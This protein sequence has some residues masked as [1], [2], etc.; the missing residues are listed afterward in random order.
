MNEAEE[1]FGEFVIAGANAA[2][3]FDATDGVFDRLSA[4]VEAAVEM[5]R[6]PTNAFRQNAATILLGVHTKISDSGGVRVLKYL[7]EFHLN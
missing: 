2:L 7:V 1:N 6:V 3:G 4:C 5:D